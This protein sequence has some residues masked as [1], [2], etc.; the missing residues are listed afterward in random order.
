[1]F[2]AEYRKMVAYECSK[3]TRVVLK[4]IF[5]D[6]QTSMQECA[7]R[8]LM[9]QESVDYVVVGMRKPCYVNEIVSLLE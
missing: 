9:Q 4:D 6:C 7:L 1:M 2:L 3:N 8:F 5:K